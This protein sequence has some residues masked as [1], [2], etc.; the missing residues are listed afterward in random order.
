MSVDVY[1]LR[2][3]LQRLRASHLY[4]S[5]QMLQSS[6]KP[7]CQ[8]C[9]GQSDILARWKE[10]GSEEAGRFEALSFVSLTRLYC[11]AELSLYSLT[12]SRSSARVLIS[13]KPERGSASQKGAYF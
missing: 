11:C 10:T 9:F 5:Y 3:V 6:R 4:H 13:S 12:W 7:P 2:K 1:W 8:F